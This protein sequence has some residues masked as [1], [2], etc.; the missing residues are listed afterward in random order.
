MADLTGTSYGGFWIRFLAYLVDTVVLFIGLAVLAFGCAFLGPVGAS[1]LGAA[2][3]LGPILYWGLM[4]ASARQATFGKSL[5]GM[6]VTDMD[7]GRLSIPRSLVRE[8]AKIVSGLILLIGFVMAA[9]TGRKQAL[10]DMIASTVVVRENPGHVV[11][12]LAVGLLGWIAPV[13]LVMVVGMG[14]FVGLMGGMFKDMQ[15]TMV[16]EMKKGPPMQQTTRSAPAP[17]VAPPPAPVKGAA[18]AAQTA[19]AAPVATTPA[20]RPAPVVE[21]AKAVSPPV[22]APVQPA[23]AAKA[24]KM[25]AAAPQAAAR[26][27]TKANEDARNCLDL[28]TEVAIVRCAEKYR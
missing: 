12:A 5:L 26:T 25:A 2:G 8:V 22:P 1:I 14:F 9:F 11:A 28:A 10:H 16:E 3:L 20:A 17:V 7:G 19:A 21:V 18:A 4:H 27:H 24:E 15:G 6:K 13:V 23:P